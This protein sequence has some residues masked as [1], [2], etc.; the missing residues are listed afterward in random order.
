MLRPLQRSLCRELMDD[1]AADPAELRANLEDLKRINERWGGNRSTFSA[2]SP[3]LAGWPPGRRLSILDVGCGGGDLL[4]AL[5]REC[6]ARGIPAL[7]VGMD[8]HPTI[9]EIARSSTSRF[10][11][12]RLVRGDALELPFA[13]ASFDFVLSS[14]VLHHVPP[15]YSARFLRGLG[16]LCREGVV[17]SDL[18]RGRAEYLLTLLFTRLFTRGRLS[19]LDGPLSVLRALTMNEARDLA[20]AA[21][22]TRGV[23]RKCFPLRIL[24]MDRDFS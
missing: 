2:L 15:E 20:L 1:P 12:I 23:V 8:C 16:A 4:V 5:A 7:L 10:A 11:E 19:R 21:G 14:L 22:W 9:L 17:I 3:A 13:G 6:R 18:R 24:L